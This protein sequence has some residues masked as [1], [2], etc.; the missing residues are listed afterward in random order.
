MP[1]CVDCHGHVHW[2][3]PSIDQRPTL[4]TKVEKNAP[5]PP[6]QKKKEGKKK[7]RRRRV[8]VVVHRK[9]LVTPLTTTATAVVLHHTVSTVAPKPKEISP[10][11]PLP[12]ASQNDGTFH[13]SD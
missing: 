7:K 8:V 10:I 9:L 3:L 5:P 1:V 12:S 11:P 13:Y 4:H 2:S 6:P